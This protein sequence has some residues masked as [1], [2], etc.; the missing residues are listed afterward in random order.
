MMLYEYKKEFHSIF[1]YTILAT[2][3]KQADNRWSKK[4]LDNPHQLTDKHDRVKAMFSQ[5][6]GTYDL[7]NHLLSFNMDKQWRRKA[8]KLLKIAPGE[9]VLDI[10]CGTGDVALEFLRQEPKLQSITGLDFVK[11]MCELAQQKSDKI[12]AKNKHNTCN[13]NWLCGDAQHLPFDDSQF[14]YASCAFGI[15]NVQ[16]PAKGLSEAFRVLKPGGKIVILE[17]SMPENFII[18][19][20][21]QAYFRFILPLLGSLIARDKTSAYKYLPDSVRSF[22]TADL[23]STILAD[24][25]FE[26]IKIEKLSFGTVLAF[27][28]QKG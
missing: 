11:E 22:K 1:I 10:C 6:A 4:D 26:Q 7:L 18:K 9:R 17:F 2:M 3:T 28:A 21:Y 12:A 19:W 24:V 15:R 16:D 25:G 14:N 20:G 23:L 13:I 8:I 27:V 5:I